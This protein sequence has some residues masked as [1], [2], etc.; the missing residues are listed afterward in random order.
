MKLIIQ[1]PCYNE[2]LNL[3]VTVGDLPRTIDGI[4]EIEYLVIDDGSADRTAEVAKEA[5]VHHVVRL[6]KNQGYARAFAVGLEEGVRQGAAVIV[7]TDGDNQ[8][9]GADVER[10]VKPILEGRADLVIGDREVEK[11]AHFSLVKKKLQKLGSWVVRVV[12]STRVP[13]AACGFRAFSREVALRLN[14]FSSYSPMLETIIQAGRNNMVVL[15]VPIRTNPPLRESRLIRSTFDYI[16][17]QTLT[18]LRTFMIYEPLR[19]FGCFGLGALSLGLLI[20]A[21]FLY[22]F[23][24]GHGQGHVQSL[25]LASILLTVGFQLGLFGL[26]ADLIAVNRRIVEEVQYRLRKNQQGGHGNARWMDT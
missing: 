1:I 2:E 23:F 14:V 26:L 15:S 21:R 6:T 20:W 10:L 12:S 5:G 9:N 25:I 3:P 22:Y 8:Y 7:T 17:Q 24:S 4:D 18:I 19:F 16:F 13:D 11:I